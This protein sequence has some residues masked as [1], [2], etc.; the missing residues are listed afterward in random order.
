[1]YVLQKSP[2]VGNNAHNS[3]V[4][5]ITSFMTELYYGYKFCLKN[6]DIGNFRYNDS[7]VDQLSFFGMSMR[8]SVH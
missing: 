3:I 4:T 8:F 2:A 6:G 5:D 7:S 1:M